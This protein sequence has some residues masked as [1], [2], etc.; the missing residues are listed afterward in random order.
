MTTELPVKEGGKDQPLT[1]YDKHKLESENTL[2]KYCKEAI[3]SGCSLRLPNIYGPGIL[4]SRSDRG[5]LNQMIAKATKN[6][7]LTLFGDG[8]KIR[9]YLYID[10]VCSAF[11]FAAANIKNTRGNYF[12]IG[13]GIGLSF[14]E[15]FGLI[16]ARAKVI[17]GTEPEVRQI[18]AP[19]GLSAIE[20]RNYIADF[21]RFSAATGWKPEVDLKTGIDNTLRYFAK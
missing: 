21:G 17:V 18:P 13:T 9:D 4:S 19:A 12:N 20:D 7:A 15:V 14:L 11:I 6:E 3:I 5:I 16:A 2:L 1:V 10:D 8:D